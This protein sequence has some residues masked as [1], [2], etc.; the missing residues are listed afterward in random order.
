MAFVGITSPNLPA[1]SSAPLHSIPSPSPLPSVLSS[2][3]LRGEGQ[4]GHHPSLTQGQSQGLGG[5]AGETPPP[6][7]HKGAGSEA[8][9]QGSSMSH[10][11]GHRV[12]EYSCAQSSGQGPCPLQHPPTPSSQSCRCEHG[13]PTAPLSTLSCYVGDQS[14][15]GIGGF[16]VWKRNIGINLATHVAVD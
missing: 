5:R 2:D 3:R 4:P 16:C 12:L 13:S 6:P 15:L 10:R 1:L 14:S 8:G 7:P 11:T 9:G